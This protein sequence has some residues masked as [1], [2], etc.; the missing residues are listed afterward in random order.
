VSRESEIRAFLAANF[1]LIKL[2]ANMSYKQLL[3]IAQQ[4]GGSLPSSFS[5]EGI[6]GGR[7]PATEA[8]EAVIEDLPT[9]EE[10]VPTAGTDGQ[11]LT[12]L[13]GGDY[14]MGWR[15]PSATGG[16]SGSVTSVGITNGG[17]LTVSGSPITSSGS[18]TLALENSGVA[19]G[20]YTNANI[21]VD[22]SG[23]ITVAANGSA[24][25]GTVTSVAAAGGSEITVSGSPITAAGT[26]T[27]GLAATS[28]AAG[29]YT[30][31]NITVDSK[32]RL[33]S[34]ASGAAPTP[35]TFSGSIANSQIAV[36]TGAD[37][38]GGSGNFSFSG[39]RTLT[40]T[41][42]SSDPAQIN[43]AKSTAAITLQVD[44]PNELR[45]T[46]GYDD[47]SGPGAAIR[48]S[49]TA[50]TPQT[51]VA[52]QLKLCAN[53]TGTNSDMLHIQTAS[54]YLRLGSQNS[55]FCHFYTDRSY[56]Y[57][58]RPIQMDGG[59]FYAYNDDLLLKTDDG[60]SG[61]PTRIFMF[62]AGDEANNDVLAVGIG[63][64]FSSNIDPVPGG[65]AAAVYPANY[66]NAPQNTLHVRGGVRVEA[67]T[68][69]IVKADANGD[70]GTVTIGANLAFDGTTLSAT[71]GGGG[72]SGPDVHLLCP[73]HPAT[74][75]QAGATMTT[76][77]N[78][79][80][81]A[82]VADPGTGAPITVTTP[83][84]DG[85]KLTIHNISAF[86]GGAEATLQF[87]AAVIHLQAGVIPPLGGAL[88]LAP[89]STVSLIYKTASIVDPNGNPGDPA[90]NG[91]FIES[92]LN[93]RDA[94]INPVVSL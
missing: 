54:G 58:N 71:G 41:S 14:D 63:D 65:G 61:Q 73:S 30:N 59:S 39:N 21:T 57:F 28:V 4:E 47:G 18:I 49:G 35:P 89:F 36:G 27:F 37:A 85:A 31:A 84:V 2:R 83:T 72:G 92:A 80:Q 8:A 48:L 81:V 79:H 46:D 3:R 56:F 67:V 11:V 33:T 1:P 74:C 94:T 26:L 70:L 32:G 13:S 42:G 77:G 45:L 5:T 82:Y 50:Y 90:V 34:A 24:G 40:I 86:V 60:G 29:A 87:Q 12:K 76:T 43:L 62:G 20:A 64:G 53:R 15:T 51:G 9:K 38:I 22:N 68:N 44:N 69:G 16:G 75:I 10:A 19:A 25:A 7:N 66:I 52:G 6:T 88:G 78:A 93:Q 23:R 55:G 17:G 91:W